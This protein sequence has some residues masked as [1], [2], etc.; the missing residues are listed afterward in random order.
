MLVRPV[1]Y[2]IPSTIL[3]RQGF[4]LE[5]QS[6]PFEEFK[7]ADNSFNVVIMSQIVEYVLDINEWISKSQK[8]LK[9][10][11]MLAVALPNF[12]N[13]FRYLLGTN[14]SYIIPPEHLNYFN[15]RS[16]RKLMSKHGLNIEKIEWTSKVLPS[17]IGKLLFGRIAMQVLKPLI[18]IL[19]K[20]FDI[21]HLGIFVTVYARK[22]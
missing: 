14:E 2:L 1:A 9:P 15:G 6:I 7:A 22:I 21:L 11:G 10:N 4:K 8:L 3:S 5:P 13:L 18:G 12:D 19:L 20:L 17:A 16:L